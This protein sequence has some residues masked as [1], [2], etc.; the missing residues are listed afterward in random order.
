MVLGGLYHPHINPILQ[1]VDSAYYVYMVIK[2]EK[3][4]DLFSYIEKKNKL[5]EQETIA[6]YR[7]ILSAV[8]FLH[9]QGIIHRD[10]KPE[11]SML[12]LICIQ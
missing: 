1:V 8:H 10:L 11:N 12:K 6:L 4:G 7:Q 3:G 2:L 5:P 9:S